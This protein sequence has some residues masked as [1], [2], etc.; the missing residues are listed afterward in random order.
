MTTGSQSLQ[1]NAIRLLEGEA[2]A[3]AA[4]VEFPSREHDFYFGVITAARDR[5]HPE[6]GSIH[7]EEWLS[8]QPAPFKEGYLRTSILI[9]ITG[10]NPPR[11]LRLPVPD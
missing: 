4:S 8:G 2:Q 7:D 5:L 3:K 10:D 11:H 9:G 6:N 1:R